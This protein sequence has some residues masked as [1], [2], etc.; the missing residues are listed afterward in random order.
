MAVSVASDAIVSRWS[1]MGF[2]SQ[3]P[4]AIGILDGELRETA[5]RHQIGDYKCQAI[6][7]NFDVAS[8]IVIIGQL[9]SKL[10][11]RGKW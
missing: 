7:L 3:G 1:A 4:H 2:V 10:K 5:P 8:T 6:S 11:S 9:L